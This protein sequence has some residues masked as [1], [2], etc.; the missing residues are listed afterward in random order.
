MEHDSDLTV[1]D[2]ENLVHILLRVF[3]KFQMKLELVPRAWQLGLLI[4]KLLE[5]NMNDFVPPQTPPALSSASW[6]YQSISLIPILDVF[7]IYIDDTYR[8]AGCPSSSLPIDRLNEVTTGNSFLGQDSRFFS[9]QC[10][11]H[12]WIRHVED[13]AGC[14]GKDIQ[15]TR[16]MDVLLRSPCLNSKNKSR[17]LLI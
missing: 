13:N 15:D 8:I 16:Q 3:K 1:E 2:S 5:Y 14:T 4:I 7:A 11:F 9:S 6:D 12:M 17:S 10:S